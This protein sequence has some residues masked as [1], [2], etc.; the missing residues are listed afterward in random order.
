[1]RRD[2]DLLYSDISGNFFLKESLIQSFFL[3]NYLEIA[4]G[5]LLKIQNVGVCLT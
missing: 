2:Q 1:M 3:P 5:N 4:Y